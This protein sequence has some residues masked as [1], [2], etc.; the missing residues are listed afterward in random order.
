MQEILVDR[1]EF[2]GQDTVEVGDDFFVAFH[3]GLLNEC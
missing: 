2:V 3:R 1:R